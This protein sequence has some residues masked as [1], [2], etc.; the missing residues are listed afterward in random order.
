VTGA[1][2]V[3]DLLVPLEE[4]LNEHDWRT[5]RYWYLPGR[6]P[7]TF[8]PFLVVFRLQ[9]SMVRS[10]TCEYIRLY[11]RLIILIH[12]PLQIPRDWR[13]D[14]VV[15]T[16]DVRLGS[17]PFPSSACIRREG[18]TNGPKSL[19]SNCKHILVYLY[20]ILVV[21]H[22]LL[23]TTSK[24][25]CRTSDMSTVSTRRIYSLMIRKKRFKLRVLRPMSVNIFSTTPRRG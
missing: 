5:S 16:L 20:A 9:V 13:T 4:I 18:W 8:T 17:Y 14:I 3:V 11:L 6:F 23:G 21:N 12:T 22:T 25:N 15:S 7:R 1:T 2:S 19:F 10:L 24:G